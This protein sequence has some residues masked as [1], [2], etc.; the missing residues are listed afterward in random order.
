MLLMTPRLATPQPIPLLLPAHRP[1]PEQ[2]RRPQPLRLPPIEDRLNDVGRQAREREQPADEGDRHALVLG[3]VGDRLR[4]AALDLT[5][6]PVRTHE[7][8]DQ[9]FVAARLRRILKRFGYPPD[10]AA[11][12]VQTVLAQAEGLLAG[13]ATS[14]GRYGSAVSA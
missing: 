2:L 9:R 14:D 7:C 10:L 8:P 3:E 4:L 12:A 1:I 11:E 13:I 6:P 5:P